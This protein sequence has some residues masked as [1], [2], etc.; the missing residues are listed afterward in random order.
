MISRATHRLFLR[1]RLKPSQTLQRRLR[2]KIILTSVTFSLVI[3]IVLTIMARP[4]YGV[5]IILNTGAAG[6]EHGM[7]F[8]CDP[9][10]DCLPFSSKLTRRIKNLGFDLKRALE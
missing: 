9:C 8:G 6:C 1:G 3:A 2:A 4:Q 7:V 5:R 10:R